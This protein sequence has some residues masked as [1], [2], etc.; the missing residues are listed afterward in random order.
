MEF[1]DA[2]GK[3]ELAAKTSTMEPMLYNIGML[4]VL[5]TIL[6]D[7]AIRDK[8]DF[9]ALLA[10]GASFMKRFARASDEN[11]MLFVEALF[12]HPIPHRFCELSTNMYVNEELRMI[13]VR[14]LLLEDQQRFEKEEEDI[15]DEK[16]DEE[17]NVT[18]YDDE[19]DDEI[20]F[21]DDAMAADEKA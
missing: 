7:K 17:K 15:D 2:L 9:E 16:H 11:P 8:D 12:K 5:D 1:D 18:A 20:E 3:N 4:T 19:E 14:D 6:N 21:N 10:F 13:A